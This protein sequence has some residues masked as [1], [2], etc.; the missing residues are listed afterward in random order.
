LECERRVCRLGWVEAE[1]G[2]EGNGEGGKCGRR[3]MGKEGNGEGGKWDVNGEMTI[4]L[5]GQGGSKTSRKN[6]WYVIKAT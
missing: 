5:E 3:E 1:V 2:K 4:F 6:E